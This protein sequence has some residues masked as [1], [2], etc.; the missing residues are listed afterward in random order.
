MRAIRSP[1]P[2]IRSGDSIP[3][4][5]GLRLSGLGDDGLLALTGAGDF[6]HVTVVRERT[7]M[8][9]YDGHFGPG[10]AAFP[11]EGGGV[12]INRATA[13]ARMHGP[14]PPSDEDAVHPWL[15]RVAAAFAHWHGREL[16]HGGA[17]LAAGGAWA[18]LG[19]NESGKSTLLGRL[20]TSGHTVLSDDALVLDGTDVLVGPRCVDLRPSAAEALGVEHTQPG[21]A[22]RVR[23]RLA[24]ASARVPLAGIVHLR[25]ADG[26]AAA[27]QVPLARR[28]DLLRAQAPMRPKLPPNK[29]ALLELAAMPTL[30]LM[31]PRDLGALEASAAALLATLPS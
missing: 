3:A 13:V 27:Q 18:V 22:G 25:F 8:P 30:E 11:M 9:D 5:Y 14:R 23:I 24:P 26:P 21:R 19:G 7:E 31:R 1:A 2:D 6:P 16:L 15:S 12:H 17:F 20:A 29:L 28:I 10:W 4:A